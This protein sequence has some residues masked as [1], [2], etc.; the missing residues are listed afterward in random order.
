MSVEDPGS[1]PWLQTLKANIPGLPASVGV[2]LGGGLHRRVVDSRIKPGTRA[3][4]AKMRAEAALEGVDPLEIT[5]PL[6]DAVVPPVH[7]IIGTGAIPELGDVE[8]WHV[9]GSV[10]VAFT[11]PDAEGNWAFTGDTP[12]SLGV[13]TWLV[14]QAARVPATVTVT[15]EEVVG[16]PEPDPEPD[17]QNRPWDAMTTHAQIDDFLDEEC[18]DQP[19]GWDGWKIAEKKTW[20]DENFHSET[21]T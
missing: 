13:V 2:P 5:E 18:I 19:D 9:E 17:P 20:L 14:R 11:T 4:R 15:V 16:D 6:P 7:D 1:R 12:A 21:T 8:L 3:Y 10:N